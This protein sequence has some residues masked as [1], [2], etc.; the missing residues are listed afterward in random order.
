M[1]AP[2]VLLLTRHYPPQVSGGARRPYLFARGLRAHGC[3]VAVFAPALPDGE[4]GY[5]VPHPA[6][7]PAAEADAPAR[8]APIRDALRAHASLPDPDLRWSLRAARAARAWYRRYGFAPDIVLSTSP[9]ESVHVAGRR[10]ARGFGTAYACDMRDGWLDAPLLAQR[11]AR[12]RRAAETPIARRILRGAALITAPTEAILAEARRHAPQT[13]GVLIAQPAQAPQQSPAPIPAPLSVLHT[14]SFALSHEARSIEP[15]AALAERHR[16]DPRY[17]FVARGRLT[18]D[19]A[20][21]AEAAGIAVR[22]PVPL[23]R[24]WAE[25][26]AAGVLV[27]VAAPGTDAVPGKLA[28]Y[29]SARRPVLCLGGGAWAEGLPGAALTP[30][31]FLEA[32]LHPARRARLVPPPPPTPEQAAGAFLDAWA[33][34]RA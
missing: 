12:H 10:L 32:A 27:L 8:P 19:E 17:A 5:V 25:Q 6:N 30:D 11:R 29:A 18:Q 3:H 31:A 24:V 14:G 21:R 7:A 13:P 16:D 26:A 33:A 20:A 1:T 4:D 34:R 9:P 23:A 15:F 22:P 2:N 28:E